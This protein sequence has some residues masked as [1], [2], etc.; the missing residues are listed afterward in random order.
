VH[1]AMKF[2]SLSMCVFRWPLVYTPIDVSSVATANGFN[3]CYVSIHIS[4][5]MINIINFKHHY[6]R[7]REDYLDNRYVP[8]KS[9][10]LDYKAGEC[11]IYKGLTH[12]L[13]AQGKVYSSFLS[14]LYE[15]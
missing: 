13:T 9:M 5:F 8:Y 12:D 11:L 14:I 1:T 2:K 10:L 3:V 4:N 7:R 6:H 15:V